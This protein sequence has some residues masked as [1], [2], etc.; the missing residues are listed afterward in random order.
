L[1]E[2]QVILANQ[3]T[4]AKKVFGLIVALFSAT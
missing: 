1:A 3:H 2:A 4:T